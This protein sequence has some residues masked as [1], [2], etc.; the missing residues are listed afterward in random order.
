M[1]PYPS[2]LSSSFGNGYLSSLA[3]CK[4]LWMIHTHTHSHRRSCH[5]QEIIICWELSNHNIAMWLYKQIILWMVVRI[6]NMSILLH[7][8]HSTDCLV[9]FYLD[10]RT[11]MQLL[12]FKDSKCNILR[13]SNYYKMTCLDLPTNKEHLKAIPFIIQLLTLKTTILPSVNIQ[14]F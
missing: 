13:F 12:C 10:F 14:L 5:G 2:I 6:T 3:R 11:K 9:C 4:I 1:L 7:S 8:S